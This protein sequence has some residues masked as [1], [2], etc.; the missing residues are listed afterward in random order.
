[1]RVTSQ[2]L[3]SYLNQDTYILPIIFLVDQ[4]V[5]SSFTVAIMM[6]MLKVS[7]PSLTVIIFVIA[8]VRATVRH[9]TPPCYSPGC[10]PS[11]LQLIYVAVQ[12]G[13]HNVYSHG[14]PQ[15]NNTIGTSP[16]SFV[17]NLTI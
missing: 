1:M 8:I 17:Q 7:S 14:I 11:L 12:Q 5:V 9:Q 10:S 13:M 15:S 3:V 6:E 2:H 16:C 4:Q